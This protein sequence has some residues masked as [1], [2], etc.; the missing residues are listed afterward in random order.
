MASMYIVSLRCIVFFES[1]NHFW[2]HAF[3][4]MSTAE[5]VIQGLQFSAVVRGNSQHKSMIEMRKRLN[6]HICTSTAPI[7]DRDV[8]TPLKWMGIIERS[9]F[10]LDDVCFMGPPSEI[11]ILK[12]VPSSDDLVKRF[13]DPSFS[14][15][16]SACTSCETGLSHSS[17]RS[18][19]SSI[20]S[21]TV[22][23]TLW[24]SGA[25]TLRVV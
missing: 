20:S 16:W 2:T 13:L 22:S 3:E 12:T 17:T 6:W 14:F 11:E 18:C 25:S 5:G 21:G 4:H 8:R 15:Y 23:P 19:E 1:I 7:P 24:R 9:P 10:A